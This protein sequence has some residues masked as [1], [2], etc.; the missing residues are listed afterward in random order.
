MALSPPLCLTAVL[1]HPSTSPRLGLEAQPCTSSLLLALRQFSG[2]QSRRSWASDARCDH[3]AGF[4]GTQ[5]RHKCN[6]F[7]SRWYSLNLSTPCCP[8]W[9]EITLIDDDNSFARPFKPI[10]VCLCSSEHFSFSSAAVPYSTDPFDDARLI[11]KIRDHL[12]S[13]CRSP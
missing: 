2:T 6:N 3:F 5:S 12:L 13:S 10:K 4:P 9:H 11:L 7:P 1:S 8:R